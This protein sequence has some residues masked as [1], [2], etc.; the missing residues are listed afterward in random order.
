MYKIYIGQRPV[1]LVENKEQI[2]KPK[3][4]HVLYYNNNPKILLGEIE[5][6]EQKVVKYPQLVIVAHQGDLEQLKEDFFGHYKI[7]KAGGG[8]VFNQ[9]EQ[10]LA[11]FRR[12]HWD[13]PKGKHE[14]GETMPQTA[15][16]EVQEETGVKHLTLEG[17]VTET[18][19]TFN[20]RKGKRCI[21]WAYWYKMET[22]DTTALVPQLEE[23]IEKAVWITKDELLLKEPI[24][25][26]IKEVLLQLDAEV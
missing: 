23:D 22:T 8:V 20:N 21:K 15:L 24:Y 4:S 17:L 18:Y 12:G 11:I 14:K 19:H 1:L 26:N 16:R 5:Q 10:I 6:L 25:K 13:L 3:K 7:V 9:Q 2:T